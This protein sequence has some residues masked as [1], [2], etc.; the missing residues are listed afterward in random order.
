MLTRELSSQFEEF[1]LQCL[2]LAKWRSCCPPFIR[3]RREEKGVEIGLIGNRELPPGFERDEYWEAF[4]ARRLQSDTVC[5]GEFLFSALADSPL[6]NETELASGGH[7][8]QAEKK[9][10]RTAS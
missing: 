9:K 6:A 5:P 4:R 1:S 8:K 3:G 10:R 2:S 7:S